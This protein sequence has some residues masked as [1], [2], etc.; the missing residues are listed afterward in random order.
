MA[1]S[2]SY[3]IPENMR[4]TI[5]ACTAGLGAAGVIGGLIG[6]G[7]DLVPIALTWV[8]MV[9]TL[10]DQAGTGMDRQT[11]K[12]VCVATAM[13]VGTFALGTKLAST[14]GAWLLAPFTGGLSLAANVAANVTLNAALTRYFGCAV[15]RYFLQTE[16]I[17][18]LDV[19]VKILI[20]LVGLDFGI[21]SPI[22]DITP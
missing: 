22:P 20:A 14:V 18:D 17:E 9:V 15:A 2:A 19:M 13:G 10:A 3:P 12:K 8:G 21:A 1:I 6:P 4:T 16:K 7:T 11:A 5:N